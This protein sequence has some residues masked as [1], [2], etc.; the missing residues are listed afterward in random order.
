MSI[1]VFIQYCKYKSVT[2]LS[3]LWYIYHSSRG[4][5]ARGMAVILLRTITQNTIFNFIRSN[6]INKQMETRKK[7]FTA[8]QYLALYIAESHIPSIPACQAQQIS[9][10]L[11]AVNEAHSKAKT[12]QLTLCA[13]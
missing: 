11:P 1:H 8:E 4:T 3:F 12:L 2:H 6:V 9:S 13:T 10:E 5:P 7:M